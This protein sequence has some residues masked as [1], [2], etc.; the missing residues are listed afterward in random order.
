MQYVYHTLHLRAKVLIPFVSVKRVEPSYIIPCHSQQASCIETTTFYQLI[1]C[2]CAFMQVKLIN[3]IQLY[4]MIDFTTIKDKES[5]AVTKLTGEVVQ[6]KGERLKAYIL[7]H[8]H[9]AEIQFS[10]EKPKE[11]VKKTEAKPK[12]EAQ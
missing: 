11:E 1:Y 3:S 12:K 9:I 6:M 2:H 5:Y 10:N 4:V 8:K 7:A